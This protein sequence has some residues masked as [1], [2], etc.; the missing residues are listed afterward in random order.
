MQQNLGLV[1]HIAH[2]MTVAANYVSA[3]ELLGPGTLGLM[4]AARKFD[5]TRGVQFS[6][7]AVP[8]IRGAM[9]DALRADDVVPRNRRSRARKLQR[10]IDRLASL[11]HR[12]PTITELAKALGFDQ[13]GFAKWEQSA[14]ADV[15]S[16]QD[17]ERR[18]GAKADASG[19]RDGSDW[20]IETRL[21]LQQALGTLAET[22]RTVVELY[23]LRGLRMWQVGDAL[24][25]TESQ[26][27]KVCKKAVAKL[28]AAVGDAKADT[29][30]SPPQQPSP[31]PSGRGRRYPRGLG[32]TDLP[33]D[34]TRGPSLSTL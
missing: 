8:R 21:T 33:S 12:R 6:S 26:V 18:D 2:E 10:A 14:S 27:S 25:I 16:L 17:L 3:D 15:M 1:Y 23:Y 11:L 29:V 19:S 30:P 34:A 32:D 4:Q 20:D 7:F 22:E 13:A 31:K 9:L 24:H 5:P 28:R